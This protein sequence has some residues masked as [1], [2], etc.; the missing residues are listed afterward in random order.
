MGHICMRIYAPSDHK[1][2]CL[3]AN[4]SIYAASSS[5][6]SS[7]VIHGQSISVGSTD[8]YVDGADYI[9]PRVKSRF[10]FLPPNIPATWNGDD[11]F[12]SETSSRLCDCT[13]CKH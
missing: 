6:L 8:R 4:Q 2:G 12:R 13:S 5:L 3:E 1:Y 11:E 10:G 9:R 7:L